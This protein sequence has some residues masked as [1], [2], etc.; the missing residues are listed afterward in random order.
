MN[1]KNTSADTYMLGRTQEETRRLQLQAQI[2][3]PFTRRL[4]EQ[5]GIM[6]GMK[7]NVQT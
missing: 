5:A 1:E 3:S 6:A 4:F 7:E 2:L